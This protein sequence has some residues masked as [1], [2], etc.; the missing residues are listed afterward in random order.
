MIKPINNRV[1]ISIPEDSDRTSTGLYLS[2]D[3][4]KDTPFEGVI[5]AID[6]EIKSVKVGDKV[7]F[8]KHGHFKIKDEDKI[9]LD[10][11][12]ILAILV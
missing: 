8:V 6:E 1:L 7:L 11:A 2:P 9:L 10:V 4:I 3:R 5:E 12:D